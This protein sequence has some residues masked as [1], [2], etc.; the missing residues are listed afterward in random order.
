[1]SAA[2]ALAVAAPPEAVRKP[3]PAAERPRPR[4]D[5]GHYGAASIGWQDM[6]ASGAD[7][8]DPPDAVHAALREPG[9][10]LD[11][12]TRGFMQ[13]RFGQD[14]S[15]VRTH[16]SAAAASSARTLHAHAYTYGRDIVFGAGEYRPQSPI[17]R[18]L[19]AHELSHVVQ[20][21]GRALPPAPRLG[22]VED[23]AEREADVAAA[24]VLA[25]RRAQ[26]PAAA[27]SPCIRR[28]FFGTLLNV[29]AAP[30][31]A[32]Y[33]LFGGEYYY[34][35]TLREYLAGLR[36]R[37]S[38][39]NNYDSDNKA[40]ACVSRTSEFGPYDTATRTL[41]IREMMKGW[42]S[43]GDESSILVLLRSGPRSE[44]DQ[45]VGAI[46]RAA[47][48]EK[49]GGKNRRVLEA[50]TLSAADAGPDL[51]TRLRALSADDLSDYS[52]NADD[53]QV[54]AA[55]RRAAA[56]QRITA[57]VPST[58]AVDA[59]GTATFQIKGV[60][61][62]ALPDSPSNA[63]RMRGRAATGFGLV[64]AQAPAAMID[65][66][67]GHISSITPPRLQARVHTEFGSDYNP[68][69]TSGY[70]RGTTQDDK[71][72]RNTGLR[73]HESQHAADWFEF[74]RQNEV[75]V[76]RGAVG[77]S[78]AD[79]HLAE[80][81]LEDDIRDYN[82]RAVEYSVRMTDCPGVQATEEQLAPFGLSASICRQ[83]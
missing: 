21:R 51:V 16:T 54:L 50:L 35:E 32:L 53:P 65:Q 60:D 43:G 14:F 6:Q 77:M 34:P 37:G 9:Q 17:G 68:N 29:L 42:V 26:V 10:P 49:F 24:A 40:R 48:W 38:I 11:E 44:R 28:S 45:I 7:E 47:L 55:A 3:P 80:Q 41:L 39:E 46:G 36:Q 78:E 30:F 58:A 23:S 70:G 64:V 5:G 79:Y 73:F 33:R 82:R 67:T 62:V 8:Q 59:Q 22:A 15:G 63:E 12:N 69:G 56:L 19:L 72:R 2:K 31:V 27:A 75:P 20:Q 74:L 1:M 61:V 76:F 25:G 18:G 83:R 13:A 81:Q 71:A 4:T 66:A 52:A 57:P